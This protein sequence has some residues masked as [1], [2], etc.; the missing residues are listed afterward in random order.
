MLYDIYILLI[1]I[2]KNILESLPFGLELF[3]AILKNF[4]L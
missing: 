2:S 3:T 1:L 4:I